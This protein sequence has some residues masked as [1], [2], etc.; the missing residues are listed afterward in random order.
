[1]DRAGIG[2]RK[3]ISLLLALNLGVFLAGMALQYWSPAERA[4]LVF[5]AEKITLLAVPPV[6]SARTPAAQQAVDPDIQPNPQTS[7]PPAQTETEV[8]ANPRCLSWKS[9]DAKSLM[10]IEANLKQAGIAANAYDFELQKKLGWWVFLPPAENKEALQAMIDEVR[11]LGVT[12]YAAVRGGPM[13][14]ALSL[15]AF[16]K[17]SQAREH[18]AR[19]SKKGIKGV[20]FGPR[21]EAGEVRLL[22]SESVPGSALAK[23]GSGWPKGQQ[24]E[25]CALQ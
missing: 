3:L 23:A 10:A 7:P 2:S 25:R 15:G 4:P 9:L 13:L 11:R 14:N 20:Q 21:P 16:A 6:S 17:F 8:E 18:T 5:N 19:L 12:D 24:P 22:L 1:M